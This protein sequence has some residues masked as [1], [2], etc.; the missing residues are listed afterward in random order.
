MAGHTHTMHQV[1][2]E[3]P[4]TIDNVSGKGEGLDAWSF[5]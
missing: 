4:M 3:K 1:R 5:Y 2:V